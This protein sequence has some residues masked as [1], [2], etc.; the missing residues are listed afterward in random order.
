MFSI[1]HLSQLKVK[2]IVAK[3]EYIIIYIALGWSSSWRELGFSS[4]SGRSL[5]LHGLGSSGLDIFNLSIEVSDKVGVRAAAGGGI[6]TGVT[7]GVLTSV[8]AGISFPKGCFKK[9]ERVNMKSTGRQ[10]ML[11]QIVF[12]ILAYKW[13]QWLIIIIKALNGKI[14]KLV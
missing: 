8:M 13:Q 3:G 6:V 10:D 5:S 7:A 12:N 1:G 11:F 14:S 9:K 4:S 2:C